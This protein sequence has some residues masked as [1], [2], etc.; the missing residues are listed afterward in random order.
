[1]FLQSFDNLSPAARQLL[2]GC[3]AAYARLVV[4]AHASQPLAPVTLRSLAPAELFVHPVRHGDEAA[5]VLAGLWLWF[6]DLDR[7][8]R[9]V[10]DIASASGSFWH[11]ITHR[12]EG[13]FSNSKYWYARCADHPALPVLR[14]QALPL[15]AELGA[16]DYAPGAL[17]DLVRAVH[18]RPD[19]P[20]HGVA[21][22]V[23]QL[24][25]QVLFDQCVQAAVAG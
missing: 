21:V 23:Q 25:W 24:E 12:R 18:D 8:H 7:A 16:A 9:I 5:C 1:M 22:R 3:E 19:D 2:D 4:P 13:D 15:V 14:A 11:A 6:D 17:V 20:R 10:Q